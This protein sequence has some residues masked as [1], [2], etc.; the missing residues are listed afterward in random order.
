MAS[1]GNNERIVQRTQEELWRDWV[2]KKV[3]FYI[4]TGK[5]DNVTIAALNAWLANFGDEGEK[6]ALAL[7]NHF[8]YYSALDERRL[9]QYAIANVVFRDHLLNIDR[10]NSFSCANEVLSRE[11]NDRIKET[12]VVPLLS[13]GNPTE[14]GNAIA[15]VYTTTGLIPEN[16]V[17]RPDQIL[18]CIY[19]GSCKRFLFVD[20]F[21]GSGDQLV[22]FWNEPSILLSAGGEKVALA[23]ISKRHT[24]IS[25]EY[26]ALVATACGLQ[27]VEQ[28]TLGLKV[29]FCEELSDEYGAFSANSIFFDKSEDREACKA[30]LETLCQARHIHARGY[31]ELDFAIAFHHGTPDSCLPIFWE[32]SD[33]WTPL[34]QPRM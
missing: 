15:R 11:L 31:H 17:I 19:Q 7:L 25:F 28:K 27:N 9:C 26:I 5:W 3:E 8:I 12:Q 4:W 24:N 29:H 33:T 18:P 1:W 21:L 6:Y 20:D 34:F 10:S 32:K 22:S 30:Y 13:E 14:S 2:R 16:Q 23:N